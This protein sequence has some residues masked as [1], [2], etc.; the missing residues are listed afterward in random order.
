MTDSDERIYVEA[1]ADPEGF[2]S[3]W[4]SELHWFRR[5]NRVLEW[6]PPQSRWFVGGTLNA[7]YNCLDRHLDGPRR[8]KRRWSGRASRVMSGATPTRS[9]TGRS[10]ARPTR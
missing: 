9:C 4:A 8:T 7:A 6:E 5:W 3:G 2:W 10:A 1:E